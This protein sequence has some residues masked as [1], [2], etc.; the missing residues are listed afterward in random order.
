MDE[1]R[2]RFDGAVVDGMTPLVSNDVDAVYVDGRLDRVEWTH[3]D[4]GG[5]R[6][7]E[8]VP[9]SRVQRLFVRDDSA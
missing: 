6:W 3:V 7:R 1:R 2:E 4:R 8:V 9:A 5:E